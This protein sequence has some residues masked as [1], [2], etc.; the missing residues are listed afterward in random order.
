[1]E[2]K[3]Q[4]MKE[5]DT[6]HSW[7]AEQKKLWFW[8]RAGRLPFKLLDRITPQFI[9]NK[10]GQILNE[11]G[12]YL[13]TGGRY[14]YKE[15]DIFKRFIEK[16]G[17]QEVTLDVISQLSLEDMDEISDQIIQS[18]KNVAMTQGATTGFGGLFTLTIDIPIILGISL[19]TLQEV[20]LSYGYDPNDEKERV[21][22]VKCLQFVSSDI[23]GKQ[24]ILSELTANDDSKSNDQTISQ[25]QG[26]NEVMMTYRDNLGWK[27]LFQL[28]PL[29]GMVFGALIN[30]SMI[31]DIGETGKMFY[32]KRRIMDKLSL[33]EATEI[34]VAKT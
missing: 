24:A 1:M 4:L 20:A 32:K 18:R 8:E 29:A 26:W 22:I 13:Q 9:H 31:S 14:L 28:I 12:S 6:I 7:E 27:K 5:L 2:T 17:E 19:K 10:I 34:E 25:V 3:E 11:I 30:K 15:R 33:F 16:S 23:V 21:F